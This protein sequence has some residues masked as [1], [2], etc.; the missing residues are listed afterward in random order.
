MSWSRP[1]KT[2]WGAWRSEKE[3]DGELFSKEIKS[4]EIDHGNHAHFHKD[5]ITLT[6]D[7]K[8]I[9]I[10]KPWIF[11]ILPI[12]SYHKRISLINLWYPL[13]WFQYLKS[14]NEYRIIYSLKSIPFSCSE[15]Q[16]I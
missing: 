10:P 11:K 16:S 8:K 4:G 6:K 2:S 3:G 7:G 12:Y 9:Q 5:G 13:F 1:E 14:K 15:N